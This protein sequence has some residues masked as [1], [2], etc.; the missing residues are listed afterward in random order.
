MGLRAGYAISLILASFGLGMIVGPFVISVLTYAPCGYCADRNYGPGGD[1]VLAIA[2][3][4]LLGVSAVV[5]L[6][7]WRP[8]LDPKIA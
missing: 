8:R 5:A 3:I 7:A 6:N 1:P 4:S 2:G